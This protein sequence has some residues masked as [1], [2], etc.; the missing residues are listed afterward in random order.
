MTKI[1]IFNYFQYSNLYK[2]CNIYMSISFFLFQI[3]KCIRN[4]NSLYDKDD[5][6]HTQTFNSVFLSKIENFKS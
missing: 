2:L 5:N 1:F 3:I 4:Y 6:T